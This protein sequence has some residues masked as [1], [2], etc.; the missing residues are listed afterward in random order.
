MFSNVVVKSVSSCGVY[1]VS[2]GTQYTP[3]LETLYTNIAEHLTTYFYRIS[4][5]NCN[6]SKVLHRLPDDGP[7][8][9]K[10]LGAI[11]RYFNCIF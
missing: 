6:I 11:M 9:P 7:G 3:Q 8:G 10:H 4:A 1:C 2:R 5:Q